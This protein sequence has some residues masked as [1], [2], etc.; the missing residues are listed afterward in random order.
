MLTREQLRRLAIIWIFG[1]VT[2]SLQPLRPEG[3]P[4]SIVHN[5]W[6]VISFGA[7]A[8]TLFALSRSGKQAST[9]AVGIFCLIIGIESSQHLLYK[10]PFE[11][12]DMRDD[13][14]GVALAWMLV[15]WTGIKFLL[16]RADA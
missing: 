14:I 10:N 9:A 1:L 2:V 7:A 4:Q 16:L 11:W 5:V 15:R 6:H 13:T 12:W 3:E 8:M